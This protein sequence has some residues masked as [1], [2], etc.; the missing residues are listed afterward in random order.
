[1]YGQIRIE[2]P[3]PLLESCQCCMLTSPKGVSGLVHPCLWSAGS[4]RTA[5]QHVH[6]EVHASIYSVRPMV[7]NVFWAKA[8][9]CTSKHV[10]TQVLPSRASEF[11][12][13]LFQAGPA[14]NIQ[15]C[16]IQPPPA[17]WCVCVCVNDRSFPHVHPLEGFERPG[18]SGV[19]L[20]V[21]GN[22]WKLPAII[23][24]E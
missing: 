15:P 24:G 10:Q 16:G 20:Y 5:S 2:P 18:R 12:G 22:I 17:P 3:Q 4:G 6:P 23:F 7:G 9:R 13:C 8:S 19:S 1:M 14:R 11:A 21:P